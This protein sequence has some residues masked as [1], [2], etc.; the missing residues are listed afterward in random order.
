MLQRSARNA[1]SNGTDHRSPVEQNSAI[2]DYL[3][4][5]NSRWRNS[6]MRP[7]DRIR[8]RLT[9]PHLEPLPAKAV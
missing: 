5:R 6:P 4:R 7:Q 3:R 8:H 9:R 2:A 1:D